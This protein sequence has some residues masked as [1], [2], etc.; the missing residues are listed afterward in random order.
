MKALIL[1]CDGVLY[2]EY[3]V[4]LSKILSIMKNLAFYSY[5]ITPENYEKISKETIEK[6][7]E[8]MFNF[9]F[10]LMGKNMDLFH[11]FCKKMINLTD[12]SNIKRD[13]ELFELLLKT[14]KK[15]ELYILTNNYVTH[16][17]KVY[18]NLFGINLENFPFK[19]YDIT[20]TYKDGKFHPKQSENGFINF[21]QKINKKNNE[22]IVCDDSK[23]NIKRCIEYNI[24][25]EY[26][27][28]NN[29]LKNVLKK[30]NQ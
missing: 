20:S 30:L 27:T 2:P 5:N 10:N 28:Q 3:Q 12:Y 8:G 17:N 11:K 6:K 25:Y 15:Y 13:D 26:I 4:P 9:I 23:R 19:S 18:E 14:S 1:D 21:L 7:E 29:T 24:P 16:L 22:C